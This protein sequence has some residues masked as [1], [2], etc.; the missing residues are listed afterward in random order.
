MCWVKPSDVEE[1]AFAANDRVHPLPCLT[2]SPA[3]KKLLSPPLAWIADGSI[4]TAA[5]NFLP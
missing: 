1:K 2:L 3:G 5:P 4:A